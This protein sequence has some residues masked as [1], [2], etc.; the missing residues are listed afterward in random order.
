MSDLIEELSVIHYGS[1]ESEILICNAIIVSLFLTPM[2]FSLS[3]HSLCWHRSLEMKRN[4]CNYI[5]MAQYSSPPILLESILVF[6]PISKCSLPT[7][8]INCF[9][10]LLYT[11]V[12]PLAGRFSLSISFRQ[13]WNLV[14][15]FWRI[16]QATYLSSLLHQVQTNI[17]IKLAGDYLFFFFLVY[18]SCQFYLS[19][20]F[21]CRL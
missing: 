10:H 19:Y 20:I 16:M 6:L 15:D 11:E 3:S 21:I 7:F 12:R 18:P 2:E 9:D 17:P 5:S 13:Y 8:K 4:G 1:V 14:I